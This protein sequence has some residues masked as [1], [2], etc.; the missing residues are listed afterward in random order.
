MPPSPGVQ[1]RPVIKR[2]LRSRKLKPV[3]SLPPIVPRN[4]HQA[5]YPDLE[6]EERNAKWIAKTKRMAQEDFVTAT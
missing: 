3:G 2:E 6:A 5:T 4:M 1:V